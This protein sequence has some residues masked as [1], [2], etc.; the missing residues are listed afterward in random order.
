VGAYTDYIGPPLAVA[1]VLAALERRRLTGCGAYID[2]SQLEAPLLFVEPALLDYQVSG[3]V[4][5]R[6]GNRSSAAAPHG[7]FRCKGNDAWCAIAVHTEEDW[8]RLC[9]AIGRPE[10]ARDQHFSTMQER[11]EREAALTQIIEGWTGMRTPAEAMRELQ[12]AGIDAGAVQT[13]GD[14]HSD[15]QLAHR[16]YLAKRQHPDGE[17]FTYHAPP[18]HISTA[19]AD[20]RRFPYLGEHNGYLLKEVLGRG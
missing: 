18:F 17:W 12:A 10:L 19:P 8:A 2:L 1:A 6:E 15:P 14:L 20:V 4:A 3:R 5:N 13:P 11:Q 16:G 9:S 7:A